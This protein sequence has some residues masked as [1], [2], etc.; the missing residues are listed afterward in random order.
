MQASTRLQNH[1]ET[2]AAGI[3]KWLLIA[4]AI[5]AYVGFVDSTYLTIHHFAGSDA[6]TM[7]SGCKT[8]L[9][10]SFSSV[11][12]VPVSLL[13][14]AF[15]ASCIML[16]V[17][18][19]QGVQRA[20]PLLSILAAVGFVASLIFLGLQLFVLHATCPFCLASF[21]TSTLLF[22]LTRV[23]SAPLVRNSLFGKKET[24]SQ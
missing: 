10:S 20:R 3:E 1:S 2:R 16:V 6:C 21:A 22:I 4:M 14:S 9:D 24:S 12:P 7:H 23:P 15:Y 5:V 18:A 17:A 11:G 19:W 8:V 13:G